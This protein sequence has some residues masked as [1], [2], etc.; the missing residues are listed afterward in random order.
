MRK[1]TL[2][3][4]QVESFETT[5]DAPHLRG[6]VQGNADV[7]PDTHACPIDTNPSA[8]VVCYATDD[9]NCTYDVRECGETQYMDCTFGCSQYNSCQVCWVDD[10]KKCAID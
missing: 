4:L 3:S 6:T 8:C 10:T 1:L 2:E 5:A 7:A 9:W